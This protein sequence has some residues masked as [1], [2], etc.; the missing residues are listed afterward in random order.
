[1][2]NAG[3]RETYTTA[4]AAKILRVTDRTIRKMCDRGELACERDA[5]GSWKVLQ[6]SVHTHLETRPPRVPQ[7]NEED[8]ERL[9]ALESEVRDLIFRLG[10]SE[11]RAELT[12]K[13]ESTVGEE[14]D[15]LLEDL[16][17]ERG[18]RQ[19]AQEEARKL[20]EELAAERDKGFW[21]RLFGGAIC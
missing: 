2:E 10:R 14:R 15:R 19:Q 1:M 13:A 5:S 20:R 6:Y 7:E 18:E 8:Q 12:E 16:E 3:Q 11:A 9:Q 21:K 17:R 4:Q